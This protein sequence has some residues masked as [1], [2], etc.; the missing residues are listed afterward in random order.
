MEIK[1]EVEG[2]NRLLM[3]PNLELL[4]VLGTKIGMW[5]QEKD[6]MKMKALGSSLIFV[7]LKWEHVH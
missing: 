3:L 1:I 6:E 4:T 7:L 5:V 2:N